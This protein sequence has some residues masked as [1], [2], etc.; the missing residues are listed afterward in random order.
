MKETHYF[1]D[2]HLSG[3]LPADEAQHALRVLRLGVGEQMHLVDGRGHLCKAEITEAGKRGLA[4]RITETEECPRAWRGHLHI[5]LAPTKQAERVEWLAEK[6]TE[7]GVDEISFLSCANSERRRV[8]V[9]RME[10]IVVSAM[11]QSHSAWKTQVNDVTDFATFVQ[12]ERAGE[13]FVCHCH[14]GEKPFL[15]AMLSTED[16]VTVLVGPEGD[17]TEEEVR[18]ATE[19]GFRS[20]SLGHSRLRT[21]TA[22]LVAVHLMNITHNMI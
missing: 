15:L 18:L 14:E 11:K 17:F 8:N 2:P 6:A 19:H 3:T 9:E 12:A 10:R 22:A 13:R 7:I 16:D 20:A 21:E 4:Y 5:A 1:Y